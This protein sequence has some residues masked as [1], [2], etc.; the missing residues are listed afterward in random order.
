[1]GNVV[2]RCAQNLRNAL[3]TCSKK[4]P[5]DEA[6]LSVC[7]SEPLDK[8]QE[9]LFDTS[10]TGV[11][12]GAGSGSRSGSCSSLARLQD[13]MEVVDCKILPSTPRTSVRRSTPR[14]ST[15]SSKGCQH[16]EHSE[17]R[18]Q[19]QDRSFVDQESQTNAVD[20]DPP[21][22]ACQEAVLSKEYIVKTYSIQNATP[23]PA[24]QAKFPPSPLPPHQEQ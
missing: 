19:S 18:G 2:S 22:A 3:R 21:E 16:V 13:K 24:T 15:H 10:R 14:R 8:C 17:S 12:H 9:P 1:M 5:E 11:H 20:S 6:M 7:D 23:S 4:R